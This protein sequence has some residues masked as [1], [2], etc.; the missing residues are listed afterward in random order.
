MAGLSPLSN[1]D[2]FRDLQVSNLTAGSLTVSSMTT[3]SAGPA[4]M[5]LSSATQAAATGDGTAVTAI[6]G[7]ELYDRATNYSTT[8][9]F[10]APVAGLYHF[11]G[12]VGLT[13]LTSNHTS[14][15][16]QLVA[17]GL[18]F[19]QQLITYS[20]AT[21]VTALT[22]GLSQDVYMSSGNTA[23]LQAVVAGASKGV[24][25]NFGSS[26]APLTVFSGYLVG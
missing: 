20:T 23:V 17:A 16:V 6:C 14:A 26:T 18:T 9:T 5:A 1:L 4:F 2:V 21:V 25:V 8:G 3:N 10:T 15:K 7:D 22:L 11:S 19:A 24:A 12:Q 13:S